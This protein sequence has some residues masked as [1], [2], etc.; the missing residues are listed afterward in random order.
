MFSPLGCTCR[1]QV[2]GRPNAAA[3][4]GCDEILKLQFVLW[5]IRVLRELG[6]IEEIPDFMWRMKLV[7][8]PGK[9][10]ERRDVSKVG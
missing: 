3:M 5:R 1:A 6:S 7:Q 8:N 2:C 10:A 9:M 4:I